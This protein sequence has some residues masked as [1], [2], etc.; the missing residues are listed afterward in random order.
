MDRIFGHLPY[1]F[2]YLDDILMAS[3]TGS[4]HLDHLRSVLDFLAANGLIINSHF[5][6]LVC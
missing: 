1:C 2:V 5:S 4:A 6:S 3:P